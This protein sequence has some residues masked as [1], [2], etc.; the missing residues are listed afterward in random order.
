MTLNNQRLLILFKFPL[1]LILLSCQFVEIE[2]RF[3]QVM[4]QA[5]RIAT[6]IVGGGVVK[7][8]KNLGG[9]NL[10]EISHQF[11]HSGNFGKH[12]VAETGENAFLKTKHSF[13]NPMSH[14]E[15]HSTNNLIAFKRLYSHGT[16]S[17]TFLFSPKGKVFNYSTGELFDKIL[18]KKEKSKEMLKQILDYIFT[19]EDKKVEK[20]FKKLNKIRKNY[21]TVINGGM[22]GFFTFF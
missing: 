5:T 4:R 19:M 12:I 3:T 20:L 6:E 7:A 17:P 16:P 11:K 10:R 1:I 18:T 8:S 9:E 21:N 22:E 15:K 14:L 2:M 13:K